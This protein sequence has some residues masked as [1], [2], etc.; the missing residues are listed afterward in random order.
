MRK[1]KFGLAQLSDLCKCHLGEIL[2]MSEEAWE[3]VDSLSKEESRLYTL[4]AVYGPTKRRGNL[5]WQSKDWK[6]ALDLYKEAEPA[7]A[8]YQQRRL[9]F[10]A[11]KLTD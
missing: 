7:L 11:K 8:P 10:L 2:A 4:E 5:A 6:E 9:L 1:M 3:K